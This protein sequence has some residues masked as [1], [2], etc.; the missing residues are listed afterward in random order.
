MGK[1]ALA[2]ILITAFVYV[3]V[4]S[5][6]LEVRHVETEKSEGGFQVSQSYRSEYVFRWDRFFRYL[7]SIPEKT[8]AFFNLLRPIQRAGANHQVTMIKIDRAG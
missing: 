6:T 3:F 7:E 2:M 8:A 5:E 1:W 4:Q